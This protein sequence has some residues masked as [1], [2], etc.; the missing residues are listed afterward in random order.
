M[1]LSAMRRLTL[2]AAAMLLAACGENGSPTGPVTGAGGRV[3]FTPDPLA[4]VRGITIRPE[5]PSTPNNNRWIVGSAFYFD[6]GQA[7]HQDTVPG[8]KQIG[9]LTASYA[10]LTLPEGTIEARL[11]LAVWTGDS[12]MALPGSFANPTDKLV[13]APFNLEYGPGV[14][15]VFDPRGM[16]V[17]IEESPSGNFTGDTLRVA[18][19]VDADIP[20]VSVVAR[21]NDRSITLGR[22]S[23]GSDRQWTGWLPL[24]GL[25][26]GQYVV[27]ATATRVDGLALTDTMVFSKNRESAATA[28]E[29]LAGSAT[30]QTFIRTAQGAEELERH[31]RRSAAATR[32]TSPESRRGPSRRD[33]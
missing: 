14:F 33:D 5:T 9:M 13:R 15:A 32:P 29:P 25:P 19:Q 18:V 16:G 7:S 12:W 31:N 21:M 28:S 20:V 3:T 1:R 26:S 2:A 10:G 6:P 17:S 8:V 27:R 23:P 11:R 4:T 30:G 22:A 24:H